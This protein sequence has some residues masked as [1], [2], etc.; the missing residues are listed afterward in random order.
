MAT[1]EDLFGGGD[2][3]YGPKVINLKNVGEW[4]KG[5]VTK[6][7]NKA[8][9]YEMIKQADGK[10]KPGNQKFWVDGKPKAVPADEAE[11]AGLNPVTQIELHLKDVVGEWRGK[12]DDITEARVVVTGSA[13]EREVFKAALVEAGSIDVGD[14]FGKKLDDRDGNNKYHEMKIVH[15][16]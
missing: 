6:I 4:I 12:P 2:G 14:G 7:D 11:R 8:P 9:T 1:L 10:F 15:P 16:S 3:N 5:T 13:N